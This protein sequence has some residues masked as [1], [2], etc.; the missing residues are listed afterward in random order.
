M[1]SE[2]TLMQ[3]SKTLLKVYETEGE[4]T[5]TIKIDTGSLCSVNIPHKNQP[6]SPAQRNHLRTT[7]SEKLS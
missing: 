4:I 2:L 3:N 1:L 7:Y 6:S 5:T